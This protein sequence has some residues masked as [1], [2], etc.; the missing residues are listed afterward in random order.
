MDTVPS[1]WNGNDSFCRQRTEGAGPVLPPSKRRVQAPL[2]EIYDSSVAQRTTQ[3]IRYGPSTGVDTRG[4]SV[5]TG[6]LD[7]RGTQRSD[8][9]PSPP[10]ELRA[11]RWTANERS[12]YDEC[13][14]EVGRNRPDM[15]GE[16]TDNTCRIPIRRND[17]EPPGADV[18]V[19]RLH[20]CPWMGPEGNLR[21]MNVWRVA[22]GVTR[23]CTLLHRMLNPVDRW[24]HQS[25]RNKRCEKHQPC[26]ATEGVHG[27]QRQLKRRAAC[28]MRRL[29][30]GF[31]TQLNLQ[32]SSIHRVL[33]THSCV[34]TLLPNRYVSAPLA[35]FRSAALMPETAIRVVDVYPYRQ[36]SVN[37]EFLLLRRAPG[38]TYAGQWRMVGG[39][40]SSTESAWQTGL[41][42]LKEET[43]HAPDKLWTLPSVNAF[44]EWQED[45]VNL[46][47]AFAA[48]LPSDP[49]LDDEHDSFT[50]LPARE[51]ARRLHWPEQERLLRLADRILRQGIPPS[52]V[53]NFRSTEP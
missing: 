53:V 33:T 29:Q 20:P 4:Q 18:T 42:E 43:G 11:G 46:T 48:E 47:P 39:K 7:G 25:S 9:G 1:G 24:A 45:R 35:L 51:A 15:R 8:I 2:G 38:T 21:M 52:L 30:S 23:R 26:N 44:Y 5:E 6:V 19:G 12:L 10:T 34:D 3:P 32:R 22:G 28:P 14:R 17:Q 36:T 16:S 49:T 13:G 50:W 27:A 37:P 40:I 31:L 41:R